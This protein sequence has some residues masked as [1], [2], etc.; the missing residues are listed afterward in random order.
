MLVN[1]A[2][3][4]DHRVSPAAHPEPLG[5]KEQQGGRKKSRSHERSAPY[6]APAVDAIPGFGCQQ[7]EVATDDEWVGEISQHENSDQQRR[8]R[9]G[10]PDQWQSNGAE[11][12]PP[13]TTEI[14]RGR[15]QASRR[16]GERSL[17]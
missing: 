14:V 7:R 5:D 8:A 12:R 16:G 4:R 6:V 17:D 3:T 9:H 10:G 13:T 1:A 11:D 15:F 2:A